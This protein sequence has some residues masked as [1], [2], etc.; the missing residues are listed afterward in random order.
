MDTS[1]AVTGR[2][3]KIQNPSRE[4]SRARR[5]EWRCRFKHDAD[6]LA[7][8]FE[9]LDMVIVRLVFTAMPLIIFGLLQ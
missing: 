8:G 2:S 1:T 5:I 6:A 4:M 9:R 3:R 7:V